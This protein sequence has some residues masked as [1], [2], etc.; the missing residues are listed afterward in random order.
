M[1]EQ[2]CLIAC[3]PDIC[4]RIKN[5][6]IGSNRLKGIVLENGT[7]G[8][9]VVLMNIANGEI[10]RE[11]MIVVAS[12]A[13]GTEAHLRMLIEAGA[14]PTLLLNTQT[15]NLAFVEASL[16]CLRT[17]FRSRLAPIE[18][19]YSGIS[20]VT[21]ST[22]SAATTTTTTVAILPHLIALAASNK[23]TYVIKEC[24][25]N[26]LAAS[27]HVSVPCLVV[28]HTLTF[29]PLSLAEH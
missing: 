28:D 26:I 13:K 15:E 12:L 8:R 3:F 19:I 29:V 20:S 7:A 10:A 17:I 25:A 6:V 16:R 2:K 23:S 24:I 18:L 11:A 14:V 5:C 1:S 22:A 9:L 4:R 27:C 21:S